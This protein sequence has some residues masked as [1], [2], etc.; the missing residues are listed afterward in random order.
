MSKI[1][2]KQLDLPLTTKGDLWT[3][4]T[5][6][7]RL[8]VGTTDGH[9]LTVDSNETAGIKW[10]AASGGGSEPDSDQIILAVEVFS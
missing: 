5:N 3:Y 8:P 7:M 9:V 1:P 10:A 2:R 4:G 6:H